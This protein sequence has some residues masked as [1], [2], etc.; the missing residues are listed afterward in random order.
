MGSFMR[1]RDIVQIAARHGWTDDGP[2]ANHPYI[3]KRTSW[4]PVPVRDKLENK[5]E[6]QAILK[7]L[8]IPK[9][10]WPEKLR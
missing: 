1:G 3:L 9:S 7:Q 4:R 10:D 5:F 6:A 2:G 8:G